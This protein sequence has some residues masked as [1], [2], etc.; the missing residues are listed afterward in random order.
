MLSNV[1]T[2]VL[3]SGAALLALIIGTSVSVGANPSTVVLLSALGTSL[4]IVMFL[5]ANNA[6]AKSMAEILHSVD[7]KAGR[8]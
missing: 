8:R 4:G 1:S 7:A 6:P 3:L 2:S 5:L